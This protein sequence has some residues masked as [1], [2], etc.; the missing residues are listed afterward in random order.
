MR[1]SSLT[2]NW[3]NQRFVIKTPLK[4][5]KNVYYQPN[6]VILRATNAQGVNFRAYF[7]YMYRTVYATITCTL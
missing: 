6:I 1:I 2:N 5:A 4:S 3:A 7:S